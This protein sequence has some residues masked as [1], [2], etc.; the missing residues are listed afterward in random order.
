MTLRDFEAYVEEASKRTKTTLGHT[1]TNP[2]R[3]QCV[4]CGRSDKAETRCPRE[5]RTFLMRLTEIMMEQGIISPTISE[6][7]RG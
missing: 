2:L 3:P 4:H 1:F 6:I 7:P 5:Q